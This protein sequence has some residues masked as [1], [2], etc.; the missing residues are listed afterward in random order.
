MR[1]DA[2]GIAIP[3]L[4]RDKAIEVREKLLPES[5]YGVVLFDPKK[6]MIDAFDRSTV[7]VM[8]KCIQ[9]GLAAGTLWPE[10]SSGVQSLLEDYQDWLEHAD[11]QSE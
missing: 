1:T 5:R 6:F 2:W 4:T 11:L 3:G 9:A 7:E 10:E 8:I